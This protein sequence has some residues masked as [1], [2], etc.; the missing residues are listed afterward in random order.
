LKN[1]YVA[2]YLSVPI[3]Q[4]GLAS[5]L[6]QDACNMNGRCR[7]TDTTFKVNAKDF[8]LDTSLVFV[9]QGVARAG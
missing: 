6:S 5:F 7:L 3:D 1:L 8:H 2:S 4:E 9:T